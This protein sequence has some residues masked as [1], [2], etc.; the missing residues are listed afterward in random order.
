MN[1]QNLFYH[2]IFGIS[3]EMGLVEGFRSFSSL[4]SF[5]LSI[6]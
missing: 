1:S 3:N 4:L 5:S 2:V 6:F